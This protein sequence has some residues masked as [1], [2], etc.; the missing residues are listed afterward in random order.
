VRTS[1]LGLENGNCCFLGHIDPRNP[2]LENGILA[3]GAKGSGG[4]C[5]VTGSNLAM[6]SL[7]TSQ[8]KASLAQRVHDLK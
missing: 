1:F 6:N 5:E 8:P 3:A 2:W 7:V 4:Q